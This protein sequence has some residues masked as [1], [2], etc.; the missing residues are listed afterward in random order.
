MLY[1][2]QHTPLRGRCYFY[3]TEAHADR[4][5]TN[6]TGGSNI[7]F[8]TLKHLT[9]IVI[10]AIVAAVGLQF[11]LIPNHLTDGGVVGISIIASRLLNL[12]IAVFLILLNIPFIYLGYK[13]LG[14]AFALYSIFGIVILSLLTMLIHSSTAATSEPI[15]AAVFGGAI[16]G[17]GVGLVIRHGGTL[18]GADTVAILIDKKTPFSVGEAIMFFNVFI[19]GASGFVFGWDN[20]MYSLVAYYVAHK[21]IDVTVEGMDDS[22]SVWIVSK[23]YEEI[24]AAIQDELGEKVTY[25]NGKKV[26]GIISDGV[27]LVVITRMQEMKLKALVRRYDQRAFIVI[28]DAHEIIRTKLES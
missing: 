25:V 7:N 26:H 15:L 27:M 17:I 12:P 2:I 18:D 4:Y 3:F 10:G 5:K 21:A 23:R 19:L 20:A 1:Y 24:G 9:I 11:F 22:K 6:N 14:K 8:T 16:V 13:K 28:N